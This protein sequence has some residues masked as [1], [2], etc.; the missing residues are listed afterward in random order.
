MSRFEYIKYN[1]YSRHDE[2]H[3]HLYIKLYL[4]NCVWQ[5]RMAIAYGNCV[6]QLRMASRIAAL[7]LINN[8]F[9]HSLGS[10]KTP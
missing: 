7:V 6:W 5:L 3:R 2:T 9:E 1:G 4:V 10:V 8:L